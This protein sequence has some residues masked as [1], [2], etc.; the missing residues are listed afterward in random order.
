M[1]NQI[2]ESVHTLDLSQFSDGRYSSYAKGGAVSEG[3]AIS[4][5]SSGLMNAKTRIFEERYSGGV[6]DMN[7]F[8]F[9]FNY[10]NEYMTNTSYMEGTVQSKA[11][12]ATTQSLNKN[13][14]KTKKAEDKPIEDTL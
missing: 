10:D 9:A 5:N 3:G 12:T 2:Y 13:N 7:I 6:L 1:T 11:K 4:M 14:Q 8:C